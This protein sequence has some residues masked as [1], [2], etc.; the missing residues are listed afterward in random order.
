[1]SAKIKRR[2]V[3]ALLGGAAV[4]WSSVAGAQTARKRPVIGTFVQGTPTQNKGLRFRQSFLDGLRELGN[5]E[6][7][8]FDMTIQPARS[9]SELPKAAEQ[10]VQLS[11]CHSGCGERYCTRRQAGNI[12]NPRRSCSVGK[13]GR[14]RIGSKRFP[15]S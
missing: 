14:A 3:I 10:L 6:G 4:A 5:I 12:N 11:R 15:P 9:T 13:P 2:N 8:D 7:R 1:M